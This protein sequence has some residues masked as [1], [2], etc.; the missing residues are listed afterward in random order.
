MKTVEVV[1]SHVDEGN[2]R[3][4]YRTKPNNQLICSQEESSRVCIWYTCVDD[5]TWQEPISAINMD[6]NDI[7]IV[8]GELV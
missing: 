6:I 5:D 8:E 1:F 3:T 4:Y 7:R 2:C